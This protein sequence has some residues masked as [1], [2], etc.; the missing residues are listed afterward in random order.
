MHESVCRASLGL[1]P[2]VWNW[3]AAV[4]QLRR[5]LL[6]STPSMLLAANAAG[7][8]GPAAP[9]PHR[10]RACRAT[11]LLHH[12]RR[13]P[14][15]RM[16]TVSALGAAHPL[17]AQLGLV[18]HSGPAAWPL[19]GPLTGVLDRPTVVTVGP[20]PAVQWGACQAGAALLDCRD[21][22]GPE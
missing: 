13:G 19:P 17:G 8:A 3:T 14:F 11:F 9:G 10:D 5:R 1:N 22:W 2:E 7:R 4:I 21:S 18:S 12:V 20:A 16:S 15:Q 6:R